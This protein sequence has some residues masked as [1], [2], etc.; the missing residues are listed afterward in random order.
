MSPTTVLCEQRM[1]TNVLNRNALR[2]Q[3]V[4]P[5]VTASSLLGFL[6]YFN[7]V[8]NNYSTQ[9]ILIHKNKQYKCVAWNIKCSSPVV[10]S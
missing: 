7:A 9:T 2:G 1:V 8:N 3:A 6:N 10:L 4:T 5:Q